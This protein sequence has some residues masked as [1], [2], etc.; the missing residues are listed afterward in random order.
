MINRRG[1][2]MLIHPDTGHPRSDHV[3]HAIW[4]G[5]I[6]ELNTEPL[7]ERAEPASEIVPNTQP[8]IAP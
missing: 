4:L 3:T 1:L 7:A 6:L 5:E 8:T 2:A